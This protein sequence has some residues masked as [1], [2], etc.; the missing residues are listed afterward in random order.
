MQMSHN[1]QCMYWCIWYTKLFLKLDFLSTLCMQPKNQMFLIFIFL[2]VLIVHNSSCGPQHKYTFFL[3]YFL[4][5]VWELNEKI[6]E[7]FL[8]VKFYYKIF[9]TAN[10]CLRWRK[11][12]KGMFFRRSLLINRPGEAEAVL[13]TASSLT[14]K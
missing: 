10:F 9:V 12:R 8:L 2:S 3:L 11:F 7:I 4:Q 14:K 1:F 6:P 13:Q 5:N